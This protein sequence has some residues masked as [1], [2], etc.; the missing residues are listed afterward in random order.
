MSLNNIG[1]NS[2]VKKTFFPLFL[3]FG[4]FQQ[5]VVEPVIKCHSVFLPLSWVPWIN[6]K[7]YIPDL[8]I[9]KQN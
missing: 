5:V 1:K 4:G 3:D 7:Q 8:H 6:N 2:F 9:V